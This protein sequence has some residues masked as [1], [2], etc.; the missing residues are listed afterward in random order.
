LSR[1]T[2]NFFKAGKC[3]YPET[4]RKQVIDK[5]KQVPATPSGI[6]ASM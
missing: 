6:V 4:R 2:S 1:L 5:N 3:A